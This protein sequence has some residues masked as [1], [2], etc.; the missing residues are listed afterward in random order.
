M[1]VTKEGLGV[2]S[3]KV[4]LV[5]VR[6]EYS[7]KAVLD[8]VDLEIG[9][10]EFVAV[11]GPSGVG[12]STLLR[13]IAGLE[14]PSEGDVYLGGSLV[15]N[16]PAHR[17]KVGL[18]FQ[19]A[20]LFPFKTVR[21]NILFPLKM[22]R[23]P[24]RISEEKL[25]WATRVAR[26]DADI[27]DRFPSKLSGGE[28]QRVALAR[29]LVAN[30]EVLLL[31]EPLANLDRELRHLLEVELREIQRRS[32]VPFVYVTHNQEE[33]LALSD[34][35]VVMR[36]G[37]IEQVGKTRDV[38]ERP[39]SA[40]VASFLGASNLFAGDAR[41]VGEEQVELEWYGFNIRM[42]K[43]PAW[44]PSERVSCFV[45]YADMTLSR[46]GNGEASNGANA[47]VGRVVDGIF[48]GSFQEYVVETEKGGRI[49][50]SA[51]GQQHLVV[52]GSRVK[53]SWAYSAGRAF[54][55][56]NTLGDRSEV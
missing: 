45:R 56:S 17:R 48:R 32:G 23:V 33:A 52:S 28:K 31:D 10:S 18:V 47:I 39:T 20:L 27:L 36:G 22:A 29:G 46:E 54:L 16:V 1:A 11:L 2:N 25:V 14:F 35:V 5:G 15:T 21:D 8:K 43:P 9:E 40:F 34:R 12:K 53:V 13:V 4:R 6:K 44:R 30:P 42:P 50:V 37:R 26:I 7:R 49:R 19:D 55:A 41:E 24:V 38:Y 51:G 3:S